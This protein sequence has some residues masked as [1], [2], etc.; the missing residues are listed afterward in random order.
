MRH[1]PPFAL[2]VRFS[3]WE[4]SAKYNAAGS[5]M[6]SMSVEQLLELASPARREQW[7]QQWLGYTETWGAP[8]LRQ[9]IAATYETVAPEDVLC[10]AGAEEGIFCAMHALL[11]AG[12]H[13]I[14]CHPNYQS[15]EALPAS[16]CD[17]SGLALHPGDGWQL[18]PDELRAGLRPETRLLSV[19][20]PNNPTGAVLERD[21]FDAMISVCNERGLWLFSD[22]VYRGM[23]RDE[24]RRLPAAVDVCERGLSLGVMSK[25]YGLPG[26]RIG[27]IACRDRELLQRMERMKHYLSICNSAV[28][29]F[30]ALVALECGDEILR[31]NMTLA[32]ANRNLLREFFRREPDLFEWYEP[33]AG[34]V[35]FPRYLGA[36]GVDAFC[37]RL[38][39]EQGV[40]LMPASVFQSRLGEVPQ[41]RF[42]VGYGRLFL[43]QALAAWKRFHGHVA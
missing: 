11:Q 37:D 31:R 14:V 2:E 25:A 17:V 36:D 39:Q 1:L 41:D 34:C 12:D 30:L 16:L 13:A 18:D 26:L 3:R 27:W 15:A 29:E 5:D 38:V 20:F 4:F 21:R 43:P 32:E 24:A 6:E 9:A 40:L 28:S 22:E 19:N 7:P 23:E 33:D 42:R 35:A 10:F 8:E